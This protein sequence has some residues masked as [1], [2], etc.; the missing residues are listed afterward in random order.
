MVQ[1]IEGCNLAVA[2]RIAEYEE[3]KEVMFKEMHVT[4][5]DEFVEICQL[6]KQQ[7]AEMVRSLESLDEERSELRQ[8]NGHLRKEL[9]RFGEAI[10]K[11]IKEI[12]ELKANC[13]GMEQ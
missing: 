10:Q 8:Q 7:N 3:E 9:K 2:D 1:D 12:D 6:N 11:Q 4:R 13:R 5:M